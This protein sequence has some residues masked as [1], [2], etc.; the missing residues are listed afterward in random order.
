MNVEK[1]VRPPLYKLTTI[2][3]PFHPVDERDAWEQY[4]LEHGYNTDAL[5]WRISG[6]SDDMTESEKRRA[7]NR[8]INDM[9]RFN[10][11]YKKVLIEE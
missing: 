5:M 6:I 3:N 10:G 8:A 2:D 1:L 9:I 7:E 11:F 4:D